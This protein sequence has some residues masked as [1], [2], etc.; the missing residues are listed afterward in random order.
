MKKII[1]IVVAILIIAFVALLI[2]H[3]WDIHIVSLDTVIR[4]TATLVVLGLVIVI[5]LVVYGGFFRA[6]D[7]GYTNKI[8]NRAH[9][10]K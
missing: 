10:K 7:R 5:L 4:S 2:L 1:G 6:T 9:P 8:G 3:V